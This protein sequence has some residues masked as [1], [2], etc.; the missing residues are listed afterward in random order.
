M[1]CVV[2]INIFSQVISLGF[3]VESAKEM[4]EKHNGDVERAV[5]ELAS[6][7]GRPDDQPVAGIIIIFS[8]FE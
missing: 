2:L 1:F 7:L 8:C 3:S 6:N 5:E 4:L